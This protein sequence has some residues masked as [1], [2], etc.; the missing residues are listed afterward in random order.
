[1]SILK[2]ATLIGLAVGV[3]STTLFVAPPLAKAQGESCDR[4]WYERNKIYARNGY[5]FQPPARAPSL[6]PAA[7]LPSAS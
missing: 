7:S 1:M 3:V 4:L 6:V 5:C 2:K